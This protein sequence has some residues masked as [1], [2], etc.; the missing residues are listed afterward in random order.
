MPR[1]FQHN[2]AQWSTRNGGDGS[3]HNGIGRNATHV[4]MSGSLAKSKNAG[5]PS[6]GCLPDWSGI[7]SS[8][9]GCGSQQQLGA[10][11]SSCGF[12]LAGA[13]FSFA[14][15]QQSAFASSF[16]LARKLGSQQH[17]PTGI[18]TSRQQQCTTTRHATRFMR[19]LSPP[20]TREVKRICGAL[21]IITWTNEVRRRDL[22][23]DFTDNT[24]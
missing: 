1:A 13:G 24:D 12:G 11:G 23:T 19:P 16:T 8:A 7:V 9:A 14:Q 22:T 5:K 20:K 6:P 21:S 10:S 18:A 17:Q 3:L 15:Q 4:G 2:Q